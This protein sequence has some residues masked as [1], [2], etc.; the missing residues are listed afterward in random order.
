MRDDA[1]GTPGEAATHVV[2]SGASTAVHART[3]TPDRPARLPG[4]DALR[5]FAVGLVLLNHAAPDVFGAA[6][7][8]G[9]TMFFA[10][11]GWLITG[12]L[13]RDLERHGRVRFGRFYAARALRLFPPLLLMLAGY[14]VVEGALDHLGEADLVPASLVAALTYT[15]NVPGLP[16]GS[17]S[18]Y[19]FWT[20]ATEEQFYLVWPLV[21]AW[22]WRRGLLRVALA[23]CVAGSLA[24]CIVSLLV[25]APDTARVYAL[26][27]SW[28]AALLI[29]CAAYLGRA[30]LPHLLPSAP[31]ARRATLLAVV[32]ALGAG[33]LLTGVAQHTSWYVLGVPAVA[34]GTVVLIS[35]AS[36][37]ARLPSPLLR[38][39]VALG[40]VSYA[41]YLWN[42]AI[43]RWL[44]HPDDLAGA[45]ATVVLTLLAATASWWLVE[46]PVARWRARRADP[47]RTAASAP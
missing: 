20:L 28:G 3:G 36:R 38:P 23:V 44:H 37:W 40:T 18:L 7:V 21:L 11:S 25:V 16:H 30:E 19:H 24:A 17:E 12:V 26:P 35:S 27:T 9:V 13:M 39:A 31:R 41:A 5:G 34:V 47:A 43:A 33:T 46:R 6:G 2:V 10:L 45:S 32:G 29:G 4:L 42:A 14:V 15:M 22:G 8:I 1:R